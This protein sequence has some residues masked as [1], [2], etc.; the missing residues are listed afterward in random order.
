MPYESS[1]VTMIYPCLVGFSSLL[2][3]VQTLVMSPNARGAYL[4]GE[5]PGAPRK[6]FCGD[7]LGL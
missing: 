6:V 7:G 3:S 5:C 4:G 1:S 2:Y